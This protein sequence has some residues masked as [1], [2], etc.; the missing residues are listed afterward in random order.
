M[1]LALTNICKTNFKK[2]FLIISLHY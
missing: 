2:K 1:K